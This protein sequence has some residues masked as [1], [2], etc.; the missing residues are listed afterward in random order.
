MDFIRTKWGAVFVFGSVVVLWALAPIFAWLFAKGLSSQGA[1]GD[2]FGSV[3]ALFS[4]L[5]FAG[6]ILTLVYQIDALNAQREE[7]ELTRES[8]E[9]QTK[10][11]TLSTK[12]LSAQVT[13]ME[14]QRGELQGMKQAQQAQADHL[15]FQEF[16]RTFFHLLDIWRRHFDTVGGVSVFG[17]VVFKACENIGDVKGES[18]FSVAINGARDEDRVDGSSQ[19]ASFSEVVEQQSGS[20]I[21]PYCLLLLHALKH[22]KEANIH[23]TKKRKYG[24]IINATLT[25]D[26]KVLLFFNCALRQRKVLKPLV[27]EFSLLKGLDKEIQNKNPNLMQQFENSAFNSLRSPKP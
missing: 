5:A 15:S 11:L 26:E 18:S 23:D 16:E 10:E 20:I 3:T 27:E 7:L 17:G 9:A 13:E 1:F 12:A 6:L 19:H 4:G 24:Q 2:Q 25:P 21:K 22:I 8:V 14:H